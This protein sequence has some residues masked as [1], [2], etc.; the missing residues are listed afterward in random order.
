MTTS[1][2][3][4]YTEQEILNRVFDAT[5]DGLR[6][7]LNDWFQLF[8]TGEYTIGYPKDGSAGLS[9]AANVLMAAPF[10]VAR[11]MTIDRLAVGVTTG[12]AGLARLG[13]YN[14]GTNLYPGTLLLDAGTVDISAVATVAVTIN[15]A[16]GRGIYWLALVANIVASYQMWYPALA[17]FG[18]GASLNDIQGRWKPAF[19]YAA[20]PD[21]FTASGSSD[22]NGGVVFARVLSLD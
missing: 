2:P 19:T 11:P 10:I 13:I 12:G 21:P 15:Q 9:V 20:L 6:L 5:R 1:R 16:L 14:N 3:K 22:G 17:L 4:A 7:S 18:M 8:R